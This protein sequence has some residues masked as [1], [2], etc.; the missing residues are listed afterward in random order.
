[1]NPRVKKVIYQSPYKL[2]LTFTNNEK[3]IF[4]FTEYLSYPIY[5]TLK[6]EVLCNQAKVMTGT[7][8]WNNEVDFDPDTLYLESESL[9]FSTPQ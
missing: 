3:K 5:E 9:Q 1:M 2:V 4:D 7:V 8:V 6:N